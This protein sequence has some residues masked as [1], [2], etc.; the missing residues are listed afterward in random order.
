VVNHD[1]EPIELKT[2]QKSAPV[3]KCRCPGRFL[4]FSLPFSGFPWDQKLMVR[5][6]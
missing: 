2:P 1:A 5:A 4:I 6:L 3:S